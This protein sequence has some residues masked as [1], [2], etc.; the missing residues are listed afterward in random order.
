MTGAPVELRSLG[1]SIN[2]RPILSDID[3][4]IQAG[5]VIAIL[6]A[7]GSG[8]STMVKAMLGLVPGNTGS[9]TLF[10]QPMRGFKQWSRIGYVPQ[11]SALSHGVPSSVKEI[12]AS[13]RLSRRH[14]FTPR[15]SADRDAIESALA[16]VDLADRADQPMTT[17]SG[18]Q[19]QRALIA[20]ALAGKPELLIMDEPNAGVD[21]LN[22]Q[23]IADSLYELASSGTTLVL[24]LHELGPFR[25]WIQRCL[26][27]SEGRLVHEGSP[28]SVPNVDG[29]T[30]HHHEPNR[31]KH[32]SSYEGLIRGDS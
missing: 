25:P 14:P 6:G 18:G 21:L 19:Q 27:L 4:T 26:V 5:E 13:G 32:P 17:L 22:Q 15:T 16:V 28:D 9:V 30:H 29:I 31:I 12:V 2:G 20:R 11:H 24:V 7:N 10:G 8:K 1:V 3:A 23:A